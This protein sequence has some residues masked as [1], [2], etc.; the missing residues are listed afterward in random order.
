MNKIRILSEKILL[1]NHYSIKFINYSN[2]LTDVA[3]KSKGFI[4]S[5]SYFVDNLDQCNKNTDYNKNT[6]TIKIITISEW[7]NNEDWCNW[8]QSQE[9]KNV[10]NY[11]KDMERTEKFKI[12]YTRNNNNIF[13]L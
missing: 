6:D 3:T 5:N 8:K 11:F 1:N 7:N 2:Q 12:L 9:R 13:L 4:S 10:S